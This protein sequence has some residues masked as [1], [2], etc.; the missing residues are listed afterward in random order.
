[1]SNDYI[2]TVPNTSSIGLY[3][4]IGYLYVQWRIQEEEGLLKTAWLNYSSIYRPIWM[5]SICVAS[6]GCREAGPLSSSSLYSCLPFPS[7]LC[8]LSPFLACPPLGGGAQAVSA[9]SPIEG[10]GSV[11]AL[12]Q[13]SMGLPRGHLRSSWALFPTIRVGSLKSLIIFVVF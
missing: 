12:T 5:L 11:R 10:R 6:C 4:C 8:S 3:W 1:L 13:K 9:W 2:G 7:L